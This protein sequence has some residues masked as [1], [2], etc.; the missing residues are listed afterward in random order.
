MSSDYEL[1]VKFLDAQDAYQRLD[2]GEVS[3][4]DYDYQEYVLS[5]IV[6]FNECETLIRTN[7]IFSKNEEADDFNTEDLAFVLVHYYLG[8]LHLLL[9]NERLN[10]I[11][12]S[13]IHLSIFLDIC[14]KTKLGEFISKYIYLKN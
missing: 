8:K 11:K 13:K 3:S 14:N 6:E 7:S 1:R 9:T 12:R 10:N 5:T 4:R 2:S